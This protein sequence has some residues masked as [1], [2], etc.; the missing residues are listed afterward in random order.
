VI[1]S[2]TAVNLPLIEADD[3]MSDS[4]AVGLN[5]AAKYRSVMPKKRTRRRSIKKGKRTR[6]ILGN[7]S[8]MKKKERRNRMM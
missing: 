8:Q 6:R 3:G 1:G 2:K 4:V 7:C 5:F